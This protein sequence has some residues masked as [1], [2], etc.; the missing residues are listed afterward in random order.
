MQN[1]KNNLFIAILCSLCSQSL[2]NIHGVMGSLIASM[3]F[4]LLPLLQK[5]SAT[6]MTS[7]HYLYKDLQ[8]Q[9]R[10]FQSNG[11][12]VGDGNI[13]TGFV[14]ICLSKSPLPLA[15]LGS[16]EDG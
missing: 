16:L 14:L 4:S 12:Y 11:A 3:E 9:W 10:V 7:C 8:Y 5:S 6:C 1:L 13:G 15:E 2:S